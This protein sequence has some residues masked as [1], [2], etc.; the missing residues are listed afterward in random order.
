VVS[1]NDLFIVHGTDKAR[2]DDGGGHGYAHVYETHINPYLVRSLLEVGVFQGASLMAW[3][4]WMPHA[5]I[6]GIDTRP[7]DVPGCEV[8]HGDVLDPT[9]TNLLPMYDVIIDDASHLTDDVAL[10]LKRLWP[11]LNPGGWYVIEDLDQTMYQAGVALFLKK[12]AWEV[13][14]YG[15]IVIA[16]KAP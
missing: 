3:K 16:R 1:L 7:V 15:E 5:T 9:L 13:H 6:H 4:E 14:R 2:G 8:Y 10:A 11:H 12:D